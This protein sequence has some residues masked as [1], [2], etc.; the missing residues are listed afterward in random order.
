M[1]D[2]SKSRSSAEVCVKIPNYITTMAA[3][4]AHRPTMDSRPPMPRRS[5]SLHKAM[6]ARLRPLP[7]QYIF[8]AWH[9]KPVENSYSLTLLAEEVPDIA[10][11]YRIYNNMPWNSIRVKESIHFFRAGV[12]PLWE[13]EENIDGGCWVL[14]VRKEDG[15]AIRAWEEICVMCCGGQIQAAVTQG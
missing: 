14:K 4:I 10:A 13:D 3:S 5:S 2:P 11:F 9:S 1:T 8:S 15:R 6:I 12:K 7:F